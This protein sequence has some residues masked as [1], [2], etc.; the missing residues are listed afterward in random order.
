MSLPEV[1][2][3]PAV[4]A[5][6]HAIAEVKQHWLVIGWVT[7]NLLSRA[8]PC[9]GSTL[10][11]RS[12]LHLQSLA[13]INPHWARVVGYGPLSLCVI[14][15]KGLCAISGDINRL[16]MSLLVLLYLLITSAV[17]LIAKC[18]KNRIVYQRMFSLLPIK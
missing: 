17:F 1:L 11:R 3:G 8:P 10:S 2:D 13:P 14:H 5:L 7:K 9:S 12:R 6:R 4:S 15:K 16:M 18:S